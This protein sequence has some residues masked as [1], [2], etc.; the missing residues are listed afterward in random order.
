MDAEK[1]AR[2]AT[3]KSAEECIEKLKKEHD[4]VIVQAMEEGYDGAISGA[5]DEV[6]ELNNI[7][8]KDG[9]EFG[10][11]CVGLPDDHELYKME[12]LCPPGAFTL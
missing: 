3:E 8:Y 2:E 5:A 1:F 4:N 12:M 7:I 6:S 11:N 10:L 9:Y